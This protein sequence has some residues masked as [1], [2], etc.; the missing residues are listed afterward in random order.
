MESKAEFYR[1]LYASG[2]LSAAGV[3]RAVVKGWLS[4]AEADEILHVEQPETD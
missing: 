4:Q 2:K 3:Q 1:G